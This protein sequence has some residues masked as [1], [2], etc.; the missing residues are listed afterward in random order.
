MPEIE[1]RLNEKDKALVRLFMASC[2]H[3]WELLEGGRPWCNKL[4]MHRI[5]RAATDGQ[6][7]AVQIWE[8]RAIQSAAAWPKCGVVF[9]TSLCESTDRSISQSSLCSARNTPISSCLR[10]ASVR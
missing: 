8:R 7:A 6:V 4:S 1:P 3:R 9:A 10:A 5:E 2:F